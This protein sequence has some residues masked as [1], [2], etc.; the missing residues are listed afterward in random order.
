MTGAAAEPSG[1]SI[2]LGRCGVEDEEF[3]FILRGMKLMN[4]K[5]DAFAIADNKC[6]CCL[7]CAE[8][9][10]INANRCAIFCHADE[11]RDTES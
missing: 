4:R 6:C 7:F 2:R 8:L 3:H 5:E 10:L 11:E 9:R 1:N